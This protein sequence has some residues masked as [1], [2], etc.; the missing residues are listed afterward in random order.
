MLIFVESS[1]SAL[2]FKYSERAVFDG[3]ACCKTRNATT[4]SFGRV[5][6]AYCMNASGERSLKDAPLGNLFVVSACSFD[7]VPRLRVVLR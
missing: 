7:T 1:R 4:L 5:V 2:V 3:T 6:K